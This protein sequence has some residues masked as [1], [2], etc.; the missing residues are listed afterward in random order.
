MRLDQV[1]LR[2]LK[3]ELLNCR[4]V[5]HA[6]RGVEEQFPLSKSVLF[7]LNPLIVHIY[8]QAGK[9]VPQLQ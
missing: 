6:L 8:S 3:E 4:P 5:V 7:Y 9:C 1:S 2:C